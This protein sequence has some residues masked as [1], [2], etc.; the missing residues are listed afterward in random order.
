MRTTEH[1]RRR[2]LATRRPR[3][4]A[5]H[6]RPAVPPARP[7]PWGRAPAAGRRTGAV[8]H[9]RAM[10]WVLFYEDLV[11]DYVE[12]RAP[13]R[14][15]HL[16][17]LEQARERGELVLAGALAEPVDGALLV[18]RCDDVGPVEAFVAADPYVQAGLVGSWR[19]RPWTVVAGD[20]SLIG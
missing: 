10:F 8:G 17:L 6:L 12:R 20:P 1:V 11:D 18:F 13:L 3:R 4:V 16:A 19:A 5:G 7:P 15:D 9:H 14:A 2:P